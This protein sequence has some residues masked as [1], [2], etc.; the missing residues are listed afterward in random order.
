[1]DKRRL[2]VLENSK[3]NFRECTTDDVEVPRWLRFYACNLVPCHKATDDFIIFLTCLLGNA[4]MEALAIQLC[5]YVGPTVHTPDET[6]LEAIERF[7]ASGNVHDL[8]D[9]FDVVKVVFGKHGESSQRTTIENA[10]VEALSETAAKPS[11]LASKPVFVALTECFGLNQD[12]CSILMYLYCLA[13]SHSF[14]SLVDDWSACEFV[15]GMAISI[16]LD[17]ET[18]HRRTMPGSPL[19][20]RGLIE[21]RE[22]GNR[23]FQLQDEISEFIAWSGR[24]N[25]FERLVKP[26]LE[27]FFPLSSF[28]VP[29]EAIGIA[30]ALLSCGKPIH[31]LLHGREGT[32]KTELAKAL[33]SGAGKKPWFF[34]H[35]RK[36]N[37]G[38]PVMLLALTSTSL[39]LKDAVLIVDESDDILGADSGKNL[40]VRPAQYNKAKLTDILDTASC[41]TIWISNSIES[42]QPSILRRFAYA[43]EF[44]FLPPAFITKLATDSLADMGFSGGFSARVGELA[45]RLGVDAGSLRHMRNALEGMAAHRSDEDALFETASRLLTAK[46]TLVNRERT[47]TLPVTRRFRVDALRL[48][49]PHKSI[50]RAV[51]LHCGRRQGSSFQASGFTDSGFRDSERRGLR[52]LFHGAPGTGKTEYVRHLAHEQS[53]GLKVHRASDIL[54]PYVGE[55]ESNI[56]AMFA[57][58]E[59]GDAILLLDEADSFFQD[60]AGARHSWE[61]TQTNE[62]LTR[63]EDFSG[64][65]VCCTNLIGVLDPAV[66]RRF[67]FKVGFEALDAKGISILLAEYF[68]GL[69]FTEMTVKR[70]SSSGCLYSG[71]FAAVSGR[72]SW[73][74]GHELTAERVEM[75]LSKEAGYRKVAPRIGF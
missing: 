9:P 14:T 62:F 7:Q 68:P 55:S 24:R 23:T 36:G 45:V 5:G 44:S 27:P 73:E 50:E 4:G 66:L 31:I 67:H 52:M 75:E 65:L 19:C 60:R 13:E 30:T 6:V 64:I 51:S 70:L 63:M 28:P 61:R 40:F 17:T 59:S 29:A 42:V 57:K 16:G 37:S 12:D 46:A 58:A 71:D 48:S 33:A 21:P 32:G 56:A 41:S 47:R 53:V 8:G 35:S 43:L 11:N 22:R 15:R 2:R 74:D 39:S 3:I 54:S 1:M 25:P 72:L 20:D 18:I 26:A 69:D 10:I 38:D 49:V 34:Q